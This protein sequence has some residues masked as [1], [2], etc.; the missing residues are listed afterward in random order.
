ME[1][2]VIDKVKR[3]L[4]EAERLLPINPEGSAQQLDEAI[5]WLRR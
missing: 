5:R 4:R 1:P 3:F 2:E